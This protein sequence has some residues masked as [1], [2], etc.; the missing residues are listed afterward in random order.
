VS[1]NHAVDGQAPANDT[2]GKGVDRLPAASVGTRSKALLLTPVLIVI[3][4]GVGWLAWSVVEWCSGRNPSY[5]RTNLRVVRKADGKPIGLGRSMLR[6][7]C[8]ALLLVPTLVAC[9]FLALGFVMG[10][11]PPEGMFRQSRRAPWDMLTR[12]DVVNEAQHR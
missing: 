7:V 5:R 1:P 12:T 11:S 8:C 3:T 2:S 10:A 6:E 9:A 4:L